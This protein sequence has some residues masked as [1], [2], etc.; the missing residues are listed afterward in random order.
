MMMWTGLIERGLV[1]LLRTNQREGIHIPLAN[2]Q[3]YVTGALM[4]SSVRAGWW[5][6]QKM[7]FS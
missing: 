3:S 2:K 6:K 4:Q 1:M 5:D 7:L